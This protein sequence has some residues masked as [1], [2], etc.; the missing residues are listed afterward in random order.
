[1]ELPFDITTISKRTIIYIYIYIYIY[2][3][4]SVI[5][6]KYIEYPKIDFKNIIKI[7]YDFKILFFTRYY[8][9]GY[10]RKKYLVSKD[11]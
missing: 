4:Y 5:N 1:L 11:G 10:R 3:V 8:F 7:L 9:S 2:I 6:K